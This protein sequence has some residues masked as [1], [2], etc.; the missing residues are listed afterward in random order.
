MTLG[1]IAYRQ[2]I[3]QR[4]EEGIGVRVE[5]I[6]FQTTVLGL[7]VKGKVKVFDTEL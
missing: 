5:D 3:M 1:D 6:R 2:G 4:L 7:V